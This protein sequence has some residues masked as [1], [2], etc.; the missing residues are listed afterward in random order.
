MT[1]AAFHGIPGQVVWLGLRFALDPFAQL[2][3]G[4]AAAMVALSALV[5]EPPPAVLAERLVAL[6]LVELAV[7]MQSAPLLQGLLLGSTVLLLAIATVSEQRTAVM[8]TL[9]HVGFSALALPLFLAGQALVTAQGG[10][11]GERGA[12]LGLGLVIVAVA[13][14]I[15]AFPF[16]EWLSPYADLV[17]PVP[18]ALNL[19]LVGS[20]IGV[21]VVR[22]GVSYEGFVARGGARSA[23]LVGGV[24]AA[25][26]A[27]M[28]A[29]GRLASRKRLVYLA[30]SSATLSLACLTSGSDIG[31]LGFVAGVV[32]IAPAL[33]LGVLCT[34][35]VMPFELPTDDPAAPE[36][37][38]VEPEA[39]EEVP[40]AEEPSALPAE[41]GES[42]RWYQFGAIVSALSLG[43]LPLLAGFVPRWSLLVVASESSPVVL[44]LALLTT[45]LGAVAAGR[46]TY[47]VLVTGHQTPLSRPAPPITVAV[48]IVGLIGAGLY[49]APVVELLQQALVLIGGPVP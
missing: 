26:I 30:V 28:L 17:S 4:V 48:L 13:L 16:H 2:G 19:A 14:L 43:G 49:P 29:N 24:V 27:S 25:L 9:R 11:L 18:Q 7:L 40:A 15:A 47:S 20:T 8:A 32:G 41:S 12:A 3:I 31:L 38:E 44:V 22:L 37:S 23:I 36:P 46:L 39:A 45:A 34:R 33:L 6:A 1:G 42:G 5:D 21:L 10:P 35:T